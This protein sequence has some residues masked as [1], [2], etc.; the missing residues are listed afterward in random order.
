M[1]AY[2]T[3]TDAETDPEAPIT[4]ILAKKWRD[5]PLAMFE[6]DSTAPKLSLLALERLVAG[7]TI[8]S[9]N[10]DIVATA[11]NTFG[12]G[13]SW[14]F[15]QYGTVRITFSHRTTSAGNGVEARI[16]RTRN[17]VTTVLNTWSTTSS[18]AVARTLDVAVRPGDSVVISHRILSG[19][20]GYDSRLTLQRL[21]TSGMLWWPSVAARFE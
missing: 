5:N 10:D 3:I 16:S 18:T 15:L 13:E 7:D 8:V 6:G 17:A 1:T 11:A 9:R 2:V 20:G 14:A 19:T 12:D 4:S 21:Q